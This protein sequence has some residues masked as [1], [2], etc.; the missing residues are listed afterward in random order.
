MPRSTIWQLSCSC[1]AVFYSV[2]E[3]LPHLAIHPMKC[4][5]CKEW[6]NDLNVYLSHACRPVPNMED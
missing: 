6:F 3:Y 1:G 2:L 4:T 5:R